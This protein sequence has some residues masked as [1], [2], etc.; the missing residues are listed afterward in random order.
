MNKASLYK[1]HNDPRNNP[2]RDMDTAIIDDDGFTGYYDAIVDGN[3]GKTKKLKKKKV[4]N[5]HARDQKHMF[6]SGKPFLV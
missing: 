4:S 5:L 1:H 6:F 3:I 2:G